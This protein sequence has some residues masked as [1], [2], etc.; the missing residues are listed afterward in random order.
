MIW[1]FGLLVGLIW[2]LPVGYWIFG[3]IFAI[4]FS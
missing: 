4:L 2:K 3:A 1:I